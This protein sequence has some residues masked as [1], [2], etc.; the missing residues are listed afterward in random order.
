MSFS[1]SLDY[2]MNFNSVIVV[3][4]ARND[5]VLCIVP[6]AMFR[7]ELLSSSLYSTRPRKYVHQHLTKEARVLQSPWV[8]AWTFECKKLLVKFWFCSTVSSSTSFQAAFYWHTWILSCW[9]IRKISCIVI[10]C[11]YLWAIKLYISATN[12]P[13]NYKTQISRGQLALD[14][15]PSITTFCCSRPAEWCPD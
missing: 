13:L 5:M 7:F 15:L 1:Q 14:M 10:S 3:R 2:F 8:R 9:W 11:S 12:K 6:S 4:F